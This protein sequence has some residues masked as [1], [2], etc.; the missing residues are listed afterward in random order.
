MPA[1]STC[2]AASL[3]DGDCGLHLTNS[4]IGTTPLRGGGSAAVGRTT[5]QRRHDADADTGTDEKGEAREGG[6]LGEDE[7]LIGRDG[8]DTLDA[9]SA[10]CV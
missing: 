4:T 6:E 8:D 9:A 2:T 7:E 10:R 1:P 5:T 3:C